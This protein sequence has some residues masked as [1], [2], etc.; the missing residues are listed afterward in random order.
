MTADSPV[1]AVAGLLD[2]LDLTP[3]GEDR[4]TGHSHPTPWGRVFGGQV[5]A[6]ALTAATR[7]VGPARPVH[8]LHAYFLRP[9]DPAV[10]IRFSVDRLRDG[11]SFSARRTEAAQNGSPILYMISSFQQPSAGV[12][13]RSVMPDAPDPD[14]IPSLEERFGGTHD[15]P[16]VRDLLRTRPVDLRHVQG[17]LFAGPGAD[18]VAEQ[19]VWM[20]VGGPLPD[21]PALHAAALA[22]ASDYSLLEPV[23][24]RHGLAWSTPGLRTASLDHTMWFHR[25]FRAD[26]WLLYVQESPSAQGARGLGLGRLFRRDGVHVATVAQEGMIRVPE[27]LLG[28]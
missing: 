5:L 9:G 3:D 13:H 17:P 23:L 18:R 4:F 24:R 7:T 27:D 10:P 14:G 28:S 25:P 15:V 21:D 22:F 12:D 8:S 1:E 26:E 2:L 20:R 19:M 16:L 11:R 6:Q